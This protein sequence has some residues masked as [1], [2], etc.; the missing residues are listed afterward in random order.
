MQQTNQSR[1]H[2][3]QLTPLLSSCRLSH[4]PP[5][6]I[7]LGPATWQL[8]TIPT[9]QSLLKFFKLANLKPA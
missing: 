6:L 5:A 3:Y 9:C 2:T 8:G 1:A 4:Y 7:T